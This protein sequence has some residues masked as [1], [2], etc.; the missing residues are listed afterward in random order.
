MFLYLFSEKRWTLQQ[1]ATFVEK[2]E[3]DT[4][5]WNI[6]VLAK[7]QVQKQKYLLN[8]KIFPFCIFF[9]SNLTD[10]IFNLFSLQ[11]KYKMQSL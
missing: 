6:S 2:L 10:Q 4:I 8:K 7:K 9:S 5:L 1:N 11:N 3:V